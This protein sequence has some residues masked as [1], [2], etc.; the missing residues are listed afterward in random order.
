[1]RLRSLILVAIAGL[2]IGWVH[3]RSLK[4]H[5]QEEFFAR[6]NASAKVRKGQIKLH[7]GEYFRGYQI[8]VAENS[9]RWLGLDKSSQHVISTDEIEEVRIENHGCGLIDG[10]GLECL[11]DAGTGLLLGLALVG[12]EV[13]SKDELAVG[14]TGEVTGLLLVP[15]F[16]GAGAVV[17]DDNWRCY[18][19]QREI[20]THRTN[21]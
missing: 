18:R 12:D 19:K 4:N 11:V 20:H 9:T 2:A 6:L 5:T 7:N 14:F 8:H 3:S 16:G 13:G 21:R 1:M 15:Y 10:L 17:W